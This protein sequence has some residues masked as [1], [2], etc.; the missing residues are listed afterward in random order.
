MGNVFERGDLRVNLLLMVVNGVAVMLC[1]QEIS[2]LILF[3][4]ACLWL[5]FRKKPLKVL[6]FIIGYGVLWG[7]SLLTLGVQSLT[8]FWLFSN[9]IRHLLVP[10]IYT[11][12]LS[13]APTGTLLAVFQK[14][15]LPKSFGISTV[16]LLRFMPTIRVEFRAIRN[17]LRFRNVGVGI[18][19]TLGHLPLNF[20]RTMVPLLIRI[21]RISEELS[22]AAMVR[23]VRLNNDIISFDEVVLRGSDAG[24]MVVFSLLAGGVCT[25]SRLGLF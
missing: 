19:N 8:T 25:L 6:K 22:A 15:H 4:V 9:I 14:L 21:T 10:I 13:D 12:G 11:D 20:E 1:V 24:I 2:F 7:I 18:L 17:S 16:V 5:L 3:G 23:G